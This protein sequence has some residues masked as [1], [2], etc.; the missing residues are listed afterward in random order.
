MSIDLKKNIPEESEVVIEESFFKIDLGQWLEE[1]HKYC[2]N[3][4]YKDGNLELSFLL[5]D[6]KIKNMLFNTRQIRSIS[7]SIYDTNPNHPDN[8]DIEP[9][10]TLDENLLFRHLNM[11]SSKIPFTCTAVYKILE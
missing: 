3:Y 8:K 2:Y 9:L 6:K 11:S 7:I 10:V 5:T 1:Y 4:Q